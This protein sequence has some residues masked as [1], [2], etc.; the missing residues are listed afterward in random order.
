MKHTGLEGRE[1]EICWSCLDPP[2]ETAPSSSSLKSC[3][4]HKLQ[5]G[6]SQREGPCRRRLKAGRSDLGLQLVR[7]QSICSGLSNPFHVFMHNLL[8][9]SFKTLPGSATL[10]DGQCLCVWDCPSF[11]THQLEIQGHPWSQAHW[12]TGHPT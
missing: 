2:L 4:P 11:S 7:E 1:E 5:K 8:I 9:H 10:R 3:L 6:C 12:S